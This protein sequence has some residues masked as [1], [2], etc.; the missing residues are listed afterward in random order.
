MNRVSQLFVL[1]TI[2]FAWI[3]TI[4][5]CYTYNSISEHELINGYPKPEHAVRMTLTDG[6][7]IDGP[8]ISSH[9][10]Q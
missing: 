2:S 9:R 1:A 10:N 3:C 5:G 6:S 4:P 8:E 7:V